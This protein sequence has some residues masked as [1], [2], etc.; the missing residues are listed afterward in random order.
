MAYISLTDRIKN[1]EAHVTTILSFQDIDNLP[2]AVRSLLTDLKHQVIDAR[3]TVRD[4][5]YADTRATQLAHV[6]EGRELLDGLRQHIIKASEYN[7]FGPADVAQLSA[8][9]DDI[10]TKLT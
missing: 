6:R 2:L 10:K 9:L 1:V 5:E 4:Y 8:Q 3:L 7:I